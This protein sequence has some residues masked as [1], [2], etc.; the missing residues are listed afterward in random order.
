M[1]LAITDFRLA[2]FFPSPH[3]LSSAIMASSEERTLLLPSGPY[4]PV[5][6]IPNEIKKFFHK[7]KNPFAS[8][9]GHHR[10]LAGPPPGDLKQLA[11]L[12]EVALIVFICVA[13][14][15]TIL[16][17]SACFWA[18]IGAC[19]RRRRRRERERLRELRQERYRPP[20]LVHAR[21]SA[22]SEVE[23]RRRSQ[24]LKPYATPTLAPAIL[25]TR[26]SHQESSMSSAS[27]LR[28]IPANMSLNRSSF[29]P[30]LRLSPADL[31]LNRSAGPVYEEIN[32]PKEDSD[33]DDFPDLPP[34]VVEEELTRAR[35][36]R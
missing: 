18:I 15:V 12:T 19:E 10:V 23:Q 34:D 3:A 14:I 1:I 25:I 29:G 30:E 26:D 11:L 2:A 7:L 21:P 32:A 6:E 9:S 31:S 28:V 16:M 13:I 36:R 20:E 27:E 5:K 17:V 4:I 33:F 35:M 22:P 8:D 24:H